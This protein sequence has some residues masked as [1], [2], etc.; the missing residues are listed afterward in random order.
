MLK[1]IWTNDLSWSNISLLRKQGFDSLFL[2]CGFFYNK[3]T[4]DSMPT[5]E[6]QKLTAE[7]MKNAYDF[8]RGIGYKFF[9]TDIGW[10]LDE[11][12]NNYFW[13]KIFEKFKFC[14]DIIFYH[15]EPLEHLVET[16][17]YSFNQ[18][19][20]VMLKKS[21]LVG[22]KRFVMDSTKRNLYNVENYSIWFNGKVVPSYYW[23]AQ[24]EWHYLLPFVWIF[25]QLS[26]GCS[27]RYEY[28]I[29]EAIKNYVSAVFLY[30]G[31][32]PAWNWEGWLLKILQIFGQLENYENWMRNRFIKAT[33]DKIIGESGK[34]GLAT[35]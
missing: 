16:K 5:D 2:K 24:K 18:T 8:A 31:N 4:N 26:I 28:L 7:A 21:L 15:G 1:G 22:Y 17:Q 35:V 19:M 6:R 34:I 14:T 32:Y 20:N 23:N 29:E 30:Q 3:F 27:L 12:D 13:H 11:L 9:V 33:E 25:G 10:G